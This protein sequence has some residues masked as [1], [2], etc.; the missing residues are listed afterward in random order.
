MDLPGRYNPPTYDT[1]SHSIASIHPLARPQYKVSSDYSNKRAPLVN[2]FR[3]HDSNDRNFMGSSG[4][5]LVES[6]SGWTE[7]RVTG[8]NEHF[9]WLMP[10]FDATWSSAHWRMKLQAPNRTWAEGTGWSWIHQDLIQQVASRALD[11]DV[12][13]CDM[14]T[15]IEIG[16]L[17]WLH[18]GIL[19]LILAVQVAGL[20]MLMFRPSVF[21][22]QA[23]LSQRFEDRGLGWSCWYIG[24]SAQVPKSIRFG[25][26]VIHSAI[27]IEVLNTLLRSLLYS[28]FATNLSWIK[29]QCP[30]PV[31]PVRSQ[32]RCSAAAYCSLKS[33]STEKSPSITF[34]GYY[35]PRLH[36]LPI[37]LPLI[38]YFLTWRSKYPADSSYTRCLAPTKGD[39]GRDHTKYCGLLINLCACRQLIN[40]YCYLQGH[41]LMEKKA[42]PASTLSLLF[43][44]SSLEFAYRNRR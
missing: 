19:G 22:V 33:L 8:R 21:L 25:C 31:P 24:T 10:P 3:M 6:L 38:A 5:H 1:I 12:A 17:D 23:S 37:S 11:L 7:L 4:R 43:R 39:L 41:T 32:Q 16:R 2:F 27:Q 15:R 13:K 42:K 14:R 26:G 9:N 34:S 29:A 40:S 28:Y 36:R 35:N 44:N 30:S 20:P 18:L